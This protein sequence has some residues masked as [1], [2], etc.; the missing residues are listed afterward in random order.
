[1]SDG[2]SSVF[3]APEVKES[4]AFLRTAARKKSWDLSW[5]AIQRRMVSQLC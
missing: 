1:M 3:L 5:Q 2:P 4:V